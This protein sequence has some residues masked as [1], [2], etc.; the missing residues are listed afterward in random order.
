MLELDQ[1]LNSGASAGAI[2]EN[3]NLKQK[4]FPL[5]YQTPRCPAVRDQFVSNQVLTFFIGPHSNRPNKQSPAPIT[6]SIATLYKYFV[7]CIWIEIGNCPEQLRFTI[8]DNFHGLQLNTPFGNVRNWLAC[9]WTMDLNNSPN[10]Q[11]TKKNCASKWTLINVTV[12]EFNTWQLNLPHCFWLVPQH[13]IF[14]NRERRL[15]HPWTVVL[16]MTQKEFSSQ[17]L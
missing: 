9:N 4:L 12:N 10:R 15:V 11:L 13:T 17:L 8:G 3:I 14:Y 5:W 6:V 16:S 1:F 7:F 2:K